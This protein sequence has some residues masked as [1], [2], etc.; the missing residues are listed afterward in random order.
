MKYTW[1]F[2]NP[3][4]TNTEVE[5]IVVEGTTEECIADLQKHLIETW[6]NLPPLWVYQLAERIRLL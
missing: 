5:L 4:T 6:N 2:K 1:N 3:Y